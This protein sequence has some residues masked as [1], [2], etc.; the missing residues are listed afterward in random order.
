MAEFS[1]IISGIRPRRTRVSSF[2]LFNRPQEQ[3][4]ADDLRTTLALQQNK[5]AF[6]N[7]NSSILNLS[8]QV[9]ALS[10]SLTGIAQRVRE[11]SA[12]DQAREAQK[13]RQEEILAE[14]KLREG[15]ESV[16]ERKMQSALLKPVRKVGEKARFTLDRLGRFFMILLGG[17]LGNMALST[18]GALVS[19]DKERL[20]QLK[21]KFLDNIGVVSGIFLLFS[22]G[23]STI[24]GYI[25]RLSSR[26][27]SSAFRNLLLRPINGL[28]NFIKGGVAAVAAGLGLKKLKNKITRKPAAPTATTATATSAAAATTSAAASTVASSSST[29]S[30]TRRVLGGSLL[31]PA[32]TAGA[33]LL[34]GSTVGETLAAT[35][36]VIGTSTLLNSLQ[37]V[38]G[39]RVKA[40]L[41]IASLLAIPFVSEKSKEFY[42][43]TGIGDDFPFLN[44]T[45]NLLGGKKEPEIKPKGK[46]GD[47]MSLRNP[48][49]NGGNVVVFNNRSEEPSVPPMN[50]GGNLGSAN[51]LPDIPTTPDDRWNFYIAGSETVYGTG[52]A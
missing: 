6:E 19:G 41:A 20:E 13:R 16:V 37:F 12:L 31:A 34:Q 14:Q 49:D 52:W 3:Q 26:L 11:D 27:G 25:T 33:E 18:I 51:S 8:A 22:G 1:P 47:E 7:I 4:R 35:T 5:V 9:N 2:T 15:K 50:T 38:L 45:V 44:K 36:G 46:G 23:F 17:F 28:L 42:S 29:P 30:R 32:L 40:P 24:L 39:S 10:S 21:K 48:D 43:Q